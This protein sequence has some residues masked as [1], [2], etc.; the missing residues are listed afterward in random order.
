[1]ARPTHA[2]PFRLNP[3]ADFRLT[4]L[5]F[6]AFARKQAA[7]PS[8]TIGEAADFF[9]GGENPMARNEHRNR[10]GPTRATHGADGTRPADGLGHFTVASG[11]AGGNLSQRI[12]DAFLELRSRQ[13]ERGKF[14][15]GASGENCLQ[16]GGGDAVPVPDEAGD[17]SSREVAWRRPPLGKLQPRQSVCRIP[18]QRIH[19]RPWPPEVQS[20]PSS[21]RFNVA[22]GCRTVQTAPGTQ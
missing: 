10:I 3:T 12:P 13:I 11:L 22:A 16:R 1:M 17:F 8:Q 19:P 6:H 5:Y 20:A 15:R 14:F 9:V 18:R 7:F 2:Q 4:P 21:W